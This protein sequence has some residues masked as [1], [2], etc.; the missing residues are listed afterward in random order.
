MTFVTTNCAWG[1]EYTDLDPEWDPGHHDDEAGGDVGV[2]HEVAQPPAE[3]VEQFQRGAY[4][5]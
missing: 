1:R 4:R 2:E 3:G 5:V